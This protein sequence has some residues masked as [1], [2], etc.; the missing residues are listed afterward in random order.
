MLFPLMSQLKLKDVID[1]SLPKG[2]VVSKAPK[3][4]IFYTQVVNHYHNMAT[5]SE[6]K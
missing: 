1:V 5:Q 2:D 4:H 6:C 3:V